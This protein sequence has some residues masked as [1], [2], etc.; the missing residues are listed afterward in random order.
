M[1]VA[2]AVTLIALFFFA[3]ALY[4]PAKR[5]LDLKDVSGGSASGEVLI[6]PLQT[7]MPYLRTV[8]VIVYEL[9]PDSVYSVWYTDGKGRK[10]PAGVGDNHFRTDGGGKGRFVTSAYEDVLDDWRFIE[11]MLHPDGDPKNTGAMTEALRGDL[12]YGTH[13]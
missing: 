2:K 10:A 13:S 8:G 1:R 7:R 4:G 6:E 9:K 11:V 3:A 5:A 12:V